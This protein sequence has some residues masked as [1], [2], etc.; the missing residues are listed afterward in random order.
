MKGQ[1]SRTDNKAPFVYLIHTLFIA[2]YFTIFL[3]YYEAAYNREE[4]KGRVII[5]E[6]TAKGSNTK[7]Y[8]LYKILMSFLAAK[9]KSTHN[10]TALLFNNNK[11]MHY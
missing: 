9:S 10:S 1:E 8:Q 5:P 6:N 3:K 11:S 4:S 2:Y 7:Q